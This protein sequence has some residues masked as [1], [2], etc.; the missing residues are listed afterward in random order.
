MTWFAFLIARRLAA[1]LLA[2]S[3]GAPMSRSVCAAKL[4]APSSG[5]RSCLRFVMLFTILWVGAAM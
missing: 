5:S 4:V 1:A 2:Y 3:S